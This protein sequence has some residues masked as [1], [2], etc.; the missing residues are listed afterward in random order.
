MSIVFTAEKIDAILYYKTRKLSL[1]CMILFNAHL[2]N[3]QL[4]DRKNF[5]F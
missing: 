5:Q 3:N 1:S 4:D 2:Y